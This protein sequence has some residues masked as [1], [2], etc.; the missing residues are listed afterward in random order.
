MILP[1][2]TKAPISSD[3]EF[4]DDFTSLPPSP[5]SPSRL[6]PAQ[7]ANQLYPFEYSALITS[8]VTQPLFLSEEDDIELGPAPPYTP[9][10]PL[11]SRP[12]R[13]NDGKGYLRGK[14]G[15]RFMLGIVWGMGLWVGMMGMGALGW[16]LLGPGPHPGRRGPKQPQPGF[17]GTS[18][19]EDSWLRESIECV[20]FSSVGWGPF[21]PSD[22]VEP[23][24]PLE[25]SKEEQRSLN[26]TFYL[27]LDSEVFVEMW[28]GPAALGSIMFSSYEAH[29]EE[30]WKGIEDESSIVA[31]NRQG[32]KP[33]PGEYVRV[34]VETIVDVETG[35]QDEI[36]SQNSA[37]WEMLAA[38]SVCL[39]RRGPTINVTLP[40]EDLEDTTGD[41][42][43]NEEHRPFIQD[44]PAKNGY[45]VEIAT[46]NPVES[47]YPD[48][49][50]SPLQFRVHIALPSLTTQEH[51][52]DI[53]PSSSFVRS[54]DV[55]AGNSAIYF[56]ELEDVH[57]GELSLFSEFG[58]VNL[59]K[60]RLE[61][62]N[63]R[64][65]GKVVGEVA[66][67]ND[68]TIETPM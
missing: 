53:T 32:R 28:K 4:D 25:H 50:R 17:P 26:A 55:R 34:I 15:R 39:N 37:G 58:E 5:F 16:R 42:G 65:T 67:S 33:G 64:T 46:S 21:S 3:D 10:D 36:D 66:V 47:L 2:D 35:T 56:D 12:Q 19:A 51:K 6:L 59:K 13:K 29:S 20:S 48:S 57:I 62:L 1:E 41:S 31:H 60:L 7:D 61:N 45:G 14:V 52:H 40:E 63:V 68:M 24:V 27:P 11:H 44:H 54:L 43:Q 23:L 49:R 18:P 8:A 38:S 9:D 22:M 30:E